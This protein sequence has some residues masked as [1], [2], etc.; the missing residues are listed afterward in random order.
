MYPN[1]TKGKFN[2]QIDRA[3]AAGSI[4]LYNTH[5]SMLREDNLMNLPNGY[6]HNWYL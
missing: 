5:G 2:M 4:K 1:P 3:I 6:L